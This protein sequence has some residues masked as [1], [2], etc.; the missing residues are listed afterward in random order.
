MTG[1]R[2]LLALI[3]CAVA[4]SPAAG[5]AA[6]ESLLE[7]PFVIKAGSFLLTTDI[8]ARLDGRVG[9]NEAVDFGRTF[10]IDADIN[11]FRADAVWR[12]RPRHHL[13]FLYFDS[14]QSASKVL[15]RAIDWGDLQFQAGVRADVDT[16]LMVAELAYEY[17]LLHSPDIEV[18][19]SLGVHYMDLSLKLA[20]TARVVGPD[21]SV[22]TARPAVRE[23]GL[24]A[25]LPVVGLSGSWRAARSLYLDAQAQFFKVSLNGYDGRL[26]DLRVGATWMFTP[27]WGAGLAYDSFVT[28]VDVARD[29]FNGRL[30]LGYS[31]LLLYLTGAF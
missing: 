19:A 13:R 10:G 28:R 31:G 16:D 30:R 15:E 11:R 25:P 14:R 3:A 23:S 12:I 21:G 8:E 4:A 1:G 9:R 22:G 20:G 6:P 5:Q 29:T 2:A 7:R 26:T 17:A 24:P 18:A 27:N